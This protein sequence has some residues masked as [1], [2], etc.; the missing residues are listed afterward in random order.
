MHYLGIFLQGLSK[1]MRHI[2]TV[3]VPADTRIGTVQDVIRKGCHLSQLAKWVMRTTFGPGSDMKLKK[4]CIMHRQLR[5]LYTPHKHY[6]RDRLKD[7]E[8]RGAFKDAC[9]A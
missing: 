7:D 6:W 9:K 1:I 3:D 2:R 5:N 4:N 8:M